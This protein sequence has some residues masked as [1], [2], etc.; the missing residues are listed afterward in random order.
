MICTESK[1][2]CKDTS[3]FSAYLTFCLYSGNYYKPVSYTHLCGAAISTRQPERKRI[4][5]YKSLMVLEEVN[6]ELQKLVVSS[7]I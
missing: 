3:C 2:Y 6:E 1:K 4:E 5:N 7:N